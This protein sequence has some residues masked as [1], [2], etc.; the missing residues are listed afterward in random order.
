MISVMKW[1]SSGIVKGIRV[2]PK[3]SRAHLASNTVCGVSP[4]AGKK[5]RVV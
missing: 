2:W 4:N 1:V 5:G 3:D